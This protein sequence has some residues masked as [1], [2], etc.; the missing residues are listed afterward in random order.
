MVEKYDYQEA[1]ENVDYEVVS[2]T[3]REYEGDLLAIGSATLE[4]RRVE[5]SIRVRDGQV[6]QKHDFFYEGETFDSGDWHD[7]SLVSLDR[8]GE[9]VLVGET[10]RDTDRLPVQEWAE[11]YCV[12]LLDDVTEVWEDVYAR[13]VEDK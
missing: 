11:S 1:M 12:N 8:N 9:T 10:P 4:N 3:S 6:E 5:R 13:T 7:I 2:E